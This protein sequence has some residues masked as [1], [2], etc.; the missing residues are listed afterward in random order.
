MSSH[1]LQ[2]LRDNKLYAKVQKCEFDREEMTFVGYMVS[3]T[4]IGMDPAKIKSILEWPV[5]TSVKEVQAF[6]GFAN[7]YRKFIDGYSSLA[8]PLTTLTRKS[9]RFTWSDAA[10]AVRITS[11]FLTYDTK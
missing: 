3:P 7:F 8:T 10:A 11:V 2:V 6:L 1:I 5:P 4:G 9:M